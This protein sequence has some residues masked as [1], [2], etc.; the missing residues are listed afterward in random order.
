M[1]RRTQRGPSGSGQALVEFAF[2]F[3]LIALLAFGF[4]DVGRAVLTANTL[5]NAARQAARVA[6][7]NQI[8]PVAGPWACR[9][10]HPIEDPSDPQWTF[11][12]CAVAAGAVAGLDPANVTIAFAAPPGSDIECTTVINVGCIVTVTVV[13][14]FVP[15]TPVA[16]QLIG[17]ISMNATSTMPVERLF[18]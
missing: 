1:S 8:D 3:P 7:V 14:D 18:P 9:A 6:V 4:I 17:P 2:V 12:G 5:T 15:I 10:D 13:A 11:R 16:G